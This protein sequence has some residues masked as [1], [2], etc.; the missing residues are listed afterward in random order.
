MEKTYGREEIDRLRLLRHET[1]KRTHQ[2]YQDLIKDLG[3]K[4]EAMECEK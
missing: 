3:P 2:F 1:V 4:V